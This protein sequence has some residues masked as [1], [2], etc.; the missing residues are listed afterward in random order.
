VEAIRQCVM[1]HGV[2]G[3]RTQPATQ[4][5]AS[6]RNAIINSANNTMI[7]QMAEFASTLDRSLREVD[8]SRNL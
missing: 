4:L 5:P 8:Q 6:Y 7:T 2:P 1:Q 3:G